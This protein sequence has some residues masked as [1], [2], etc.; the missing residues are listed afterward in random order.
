MASIV[1]YEVLWVGVEHFLGRQPIARGCGAASKWLVGQFVCVRVRVFVGLLKG[2]RIEEEGSVARMEENLWR[3]GKGRAEFKR[4]RW[5][6]TRLRA[7]VPHE[8]AMTLY[9]ED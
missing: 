2:G 7:F 1:G 8:S 5:K 6:G 9:P 3:K 4:A